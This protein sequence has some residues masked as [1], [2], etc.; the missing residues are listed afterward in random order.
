METGQGNNNAEVITKLLR[1][2]DR[3]DDPRLLCEEAHK[4][5][6]DVNPKDIVAAEQN[7]VEDGL[8]ART[9]QQL[10]AAF[11]FMGM[12]QQRD[13]DGENALGDNHILRK[14]MV[15][16]DFI[17]C[18]LADLDEV[19]AQ[20]RQLDELSDVGCE[21]RRLV[22]IISHLNVMKEH[23]ERE[24]YVIF[25]Y[26]RKYGWAGLCRAAQG[27]HLNI[28]MEIDNLVRLALSFNEIAFEQFKQWLLTI[29][30]RLRPRALEHLWYEDEILYP[31]ALGV[32]NDAEVWEK[33]KAVC[34]QIGYCAVHH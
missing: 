26:L 32:I 34:E 1:R 23:I 31:M 10:S 6:Q 9:V 11:M 2:I 25:P 14:A 18:L 15:E 24:E 5:I 19:V 27:D 22:H 8:P 28:T 17:R 4:L 7:L 20:I 12:H 33:I 29:T 3:G 21:F 30:A 16:H 13:D